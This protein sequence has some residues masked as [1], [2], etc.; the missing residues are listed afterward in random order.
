MRPGHAVVMAKL[1]GNFAESVSHNFSA[2]GRWQEFGDKGLRFSPDA[3]VEKWP[4]RGSPGTRC[5]HW[6]T[7]PRRSLCRHPMGI[8]VWQYIDKFLSILDLKRLTLGG[9]VLRSRRLPS[10][11]R[12]QAS[13]GSV[14]ASGHAISGWLKYSHGE[15]KVNMVT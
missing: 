6:P 3:A 13:F 1:H 2:S 8:D 7:F 14:R 5:R 4:L 12:G 10:A 11:S 9:R 15:S